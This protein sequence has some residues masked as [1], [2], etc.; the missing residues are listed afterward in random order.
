MS[1]PNPQE[2]HAPPPPLPVQEPQA[3]RPTHLRIPG[4]IILVIGLALEV[5]GIA[6]IIPGGFFIGMG[7]VFWGGCL[8]GFSF[9]PLPKR[10]PGAPE[11]MSAVE[12][13]TAIFYEPSRVFKNLGSNPRWLVP[14]LII[15]FLNVGYTLAFTQRLG[16]ERI[17]AYVTDKMAQTPFIPPEAV[18]RAKVEQLE[19]LKNPLIKTVT[20]GASIAWLFIR[21]A[22]VAALLLLGVLVFGGRMNYWQAFVVSVYSSFPIAIIQRVVSF[23]LLYIKSPDDIHPIIGQET[24]LQDNL[25]ILFVPAEHPV[26]YVAASAIGILSLYGL[27]LK[28]V[29]LRNAGY[30]VSNAAAWSTAIALWLLGLGL[31]LIFTALFPAF[32]S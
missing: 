31:V 11:P 22:F 28:A 13:I 14:F 21:F 6:K 20:A 18:E 9:I 3:P 4:I 2:F 15:G 7:F 12:T 8:L 25:G 32:I 17:V 10:E 5:V 19:Q 29:G 23:I 26:L 30:R 24:L 16:A 1:E 27:W